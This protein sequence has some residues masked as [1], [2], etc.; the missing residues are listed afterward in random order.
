MPMSVVRPITSDASD[1]E[2]RLAE[3]GLSSD[4]IHMALRPG[5][6]RAMNRTS[7]ALRSTPG[8]DIYHDSMENFSRILAPSWVCVYVNQQPRLLHPEKRMTFTVTSGMHGAHQDRK[9]KP[10]VRKGKATRGS[11][12]ASTVRTTVM[13]AVPGVEQQAETAA[14]ETAPLWL[15]IYERTE[16][17][18]N[19]ELSRPSEMDD[20]GFVTNWK[21]R[22]MVRFLDLNGN[23]SEFDRPDDDDDVNVDVQPL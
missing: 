15:L 18:L 20:N 4:L 19:L 21:D 11:L 5:L 2:R 23:L 6:S 1:D 8:T 7:M 13:V 10:R 17:G 3:F 12:A 16:R 22:I 14:A 9:V